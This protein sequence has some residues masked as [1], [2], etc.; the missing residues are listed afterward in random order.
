[1]SETYKGLVPF[2]IWDIGRL[3]VLLWLPSLSLWPVGVLFQR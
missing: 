2:L 3:V 1:M